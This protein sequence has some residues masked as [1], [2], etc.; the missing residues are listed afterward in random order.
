M[1]FEETYDRLFKSVLAYIRGRISIASAAEDISSRT[2]Q[3][4]WSKRSQYDAS[5]GLPEQWIFTIAR[6]EVNKYFYFGRFKCL[7]SLTQKEEAYASSDKMPFEAL[8][9]QEKNY[10]L[11]RA[12]A[13]LSA[14]ERDLISLKFYSGLTNRRIAQI[15][16]LSESN[17]GTIVS[18]SLG[19]LRAHLEK[20]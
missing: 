15:T 10:L 13:C 1:N 9:S 4:A 18:R 3:K 19:K 17:V 7:F 20:L 6:N 14:K 16:E 12:L 2:W 8:E 5:K 11:L